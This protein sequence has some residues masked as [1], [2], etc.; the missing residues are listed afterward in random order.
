[1]A[2]AVGTVVPPQIPGANVTEQS[3]NYAQ[4]L[5]AHVRLAFPTAVVADLI[6]KGKVPIQGDPEVAAGVSSFLTANQGKFQIGIEPVDAY[7]ARTRLTGTDPDGGRSDQRVQRVYQ[8]TP[9][10]QSL[11]F[12]LGHNL[13]S[14]YVV[15]RYDSAG[16]IT[17]FQGAL[18]GAQNAGR[19]YSRAQQIYGSVLSVMM[20]YMVAQTG[21]QLGGASQV[22]ILSPKSQPPSS[23]SY[24]VIAYPTLEELFGSLDY[25]ACEDCRSF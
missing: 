11:A 24:P 12:M 16:F 20:H 15:T 14:A 19:I 23:P 21:L 22:P 18:G 3:A 4:M 7:L 1:M 5:A 25:C 9:D 13:D 2:A 8:M 6:G 10:D 17:S